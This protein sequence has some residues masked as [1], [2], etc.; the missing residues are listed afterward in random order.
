MKK[1]IL[2][3]TLLGSVLQ[4]SLAQHSDSTSAK[5]VKKTSEGVVQIKL[6]NSAYFLRNT[7]IND[8]YKTNVFMMPGIGLEILNKG[9]GFYFGAEATLG[10]HARIDSAVSGSTSA[11]FSQTMFGAGVLQRTSLTPNMSFRSKLGVNHVMTNEEFT[12]LNHNGVGFDIGVGLE[13]QTLTA[14]SCFV[15]LHY[16]Y[17][18]AKEAGLLGGFRLEVGLKFGKPPERTKVN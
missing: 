6:S 3:I 7:T 14:A 10:V 1:I 16:Q 18:R 11:K 2:V 9:F 17:S 5:T 12:S 8:L 15:D 4:A 13:F